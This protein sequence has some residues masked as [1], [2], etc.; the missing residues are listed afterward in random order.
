MDKKIKLIVSNNL[1]V[2][3]GYEGCSFETFNGLGSQKLSFIAN[4]KKVLFIFSVEGI[5]DRDLSNIKT[6]LLSHCEEVII[7]TDNE[8]LFL[9]KLLR[10]L[11]G[12][13][14]TRRTKLIGRLKFMAA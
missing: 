12:M 5:L 9:N 2:V 1:E 13:S 11:H 3:P 6:V 4:A 10:N 7:K 14:W 8:S